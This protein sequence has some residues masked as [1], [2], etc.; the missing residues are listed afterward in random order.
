M[1]M[2]KNYFPVFSPFNTLMNAA[3]AANIMKINGNAAASEIVCRGFS[4]PAIRRPTAITDWMIPHRIFLLF[5]GLISPFVV[6]IDNTYTP[7]F[8]DVMKNAHKDMIATSDNRNPRGYLLST[9]KRPTSGAATA[10]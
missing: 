1:S 9:T 10:S 8:A 2:P 6:S 5:G 4:P 7:E 3:H